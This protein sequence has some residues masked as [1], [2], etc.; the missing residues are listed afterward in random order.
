MPPYAPVL[1]PSNLGGFSRVT[2]NV[3]LNDAGNPLTD[4]FNSER[5]GRDMLFFAQLFGEAEILK[6]L[7]FRSQLAVSYG[8]FHNYNYTK[9]RANGNLT[10]G[11]NINESYGFYISPVLENFFTVNKAFGVHN[12]NVVLGNTYINGFVNR[13]IQLTGGNFSNDELRNVAF[14][15]QSTVTG[16]GGGLPQGGGISYFARLNYTLMDKYLLTA[17][18]RR[19]GSPV[20]PA[21]NRFANFPAVGIAWKISQENFMK[22]I[23]F[24][25]EL[26]L[27]ASYGITGNSSIPLQ[28][29]VI[30]R[31]SP[32]NIVYSF[33][34]NEAM[35]GG[36]TVN[37]PIDPTTRWETTVQTDVGLDVGLLNNRIEL[38]FDYYNRNN[39]D[40]LVGVPISLSSGF[41]G[42]F[43]QVGTVIRNAATAFNRGFEVTASFR[44][45]VGSFRY[46]ISGNAAFNRNEVVSLG[47][48]QPFNSA[49]VTGGYLAART[50]VGQPIASFFGYQIDR[51]ASTQADVDRLNALARE[52]TGNATAVY[53]TQLRPGDIIFRDLNG[54]GQVTERDQ[55]FLGSPLPLW[56][57]GANLNLGYKGIDLMI[58]VFGIAG[59]RLWNDVK[60]WTEGTTRP[61]NS[62]AALA[63]RWRREGDISEFPRAGQNANGNLNLRASD[64]FIED[65][66]FLRVRNITLGYTLP[67][68]VLGLAKDTFSSIRVYVTAQN[69]LTFTR[70]TGFDPEI[71][72]QGQDPRSFIFTRG[73]DNGQFPQPRSFLFGIQVG[74]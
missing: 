37:Q 8:N 15:G 67:Q 16:G 23:P 53:Q 59:V 28:R 18:F 55:T 14:A 72:A 47:A 11:N 21:A 74:F 20:F 38:S 63:N 29:A 10:F 70:Y 73:V 43:D 65:G 48:G 34:D 3:D 62:S 51:V 19:D 30:F 60:Y 5:R 9:A 57:Y 50:E 46:S 13:D 1:D 69:P 42:P 12:V 64:R 68:S 35:V 54:D 41:G 2:S 45:E 17:S 56:N 71:S 7:R 52:R 24:V 49:G 25:S 39:R 31:G 44:G 4:V 33:G 40:L 32:T 36:A 6:W 26:K 61:F 27:R 66:S 22:N 58:G